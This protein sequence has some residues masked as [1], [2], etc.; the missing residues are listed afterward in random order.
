VSD[1]APPE[2]DLPP[3]LGIHGIVQQHEHRHAADKPEAGVA[4]GG[5]DGREGA[6]HLV[7]A[8]GHR[9]V[10]EVVGVQKNAARPRSPVQICQRGSIACI[11]QDMEGD[12]HRRDDVVTR[13]GKRRAGV[14]EI[15]TVEAVAVGHAE[16]LAPR[17]MPATERIR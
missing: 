3:A 8:R 11:I 10:D 4:E 7:D 1:E 6:A 5:G 17:P 12:V 14:A 15:E 9:A 16:S 13:R 2:A